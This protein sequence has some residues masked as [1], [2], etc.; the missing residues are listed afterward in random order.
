MYQVLHL[1]HL[2]AWSWKT[3]Q[4]S[5]KCGVRVAWPRP[6]SLIAPA[7]HGMMA[8]PNSSSSKTKLPHPLTG[9]PRGQVVRSTVPSGVVSL[10]SYNSRVCG[11]SEP[12]TSAGTSLFIF[13]RIYAT[14]FSL[15]DVLFEA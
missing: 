2:H 4:G 9:D 8:C 6:G 3:D 5:V 15:G 13:F 14:A 1:E 10:A 12:T 11:G 7:I